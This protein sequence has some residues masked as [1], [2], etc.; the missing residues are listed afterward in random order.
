MFRPWTIQN[1]KHVYV[2][3]NRMKKMLAIVCDGKEF[4]SFDHNIIRWVL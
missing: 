2:K 4:S 3:Q 1:Q